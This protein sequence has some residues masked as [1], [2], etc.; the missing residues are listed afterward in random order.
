MRE[1]ARE[2]G[3]AQQRAYD[4]QQKERAHMQAYIDAFYNDKRSSKQAAMVKQAMSKQ[5]ALGTGG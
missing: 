3:E 2:R 1:G 5:K 4:A